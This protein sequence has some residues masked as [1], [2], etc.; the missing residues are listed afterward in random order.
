MLHC[1]I[2]T[3]LDGTVTASN[4][5][6]CLVIIPDGKNKG[7]A[8]NRNFIRHQIGGTRLHAM[9][10][11][12]AAGIQQNKITEQEAQEKIVQL[13]ELWKTPEHERWLI[14]ELNG[15]KVYIKDH[16]VIITTRD[17]PKE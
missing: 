13:V 8:F 4:P 14:G 2:K 10:N 9:L 11:N 1:D 15:V 7:R 16:N 5:E 12:I 3:E 17:L 6:F